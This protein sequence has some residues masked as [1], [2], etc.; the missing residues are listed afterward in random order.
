MSKVLNF[1][2]KLR[3][4]IEIK[5]KV[6][7]SKQNLSL[8]YTP[9]VAEVAREIAKNKENS[10][11]YTSRGNNVAI[12]ADGSRALGVGNSIPEAALPVL[13]GK[14]LLAKVLAGVDAYPICLATKEKSE[15]VRTI[16]I[17]SPNFSVFVLEDIQSPKCFEIMEELAKI[18]LIFFNDDQQG[19]A[20]ALLAGLLNSLKVVGKNLREVKICLAGAGVSGYGVFKILNYVGLKNL[21]VFDIKGIIYRGRK[22]DNKYLQEIAK[23][24]N[25]ENSKDGLK[26]LIQ[27]SD[28]FIGLSGVGNLLNSSDI[29]LMNKKPIIFALSNPDPEIFPR[30][31]KRAAK[32]YIF[33][34][35]RS[36]FPN[37]INNLIV[38]PGILK[39]LLHIQRKLN[40]ALEVKIAKTIASLV[41]NPEKNYII[42]NPLDK[43]LV[44]TIVNC[45][46]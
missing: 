28:V 4:K 31:I 33:A 22:G 18:D 36:D 16:Q 23:F 29:K 1:H 27:G 19:V 25:K 7:V 8:V 43:R 24:T 11:K 40:L 20:I 21:F 41:K 46:I 10:F 6:K 45:I 34:T 13:E 44:K 30:E 35:G 12:I 15:I 39:G 32:D 42:P 38:F 2:R 26:K 5:P 9:G 14:A 17:L 3:G 37:Q